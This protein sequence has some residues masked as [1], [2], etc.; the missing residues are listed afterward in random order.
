MGV[1][2]TNTF[3]AEMAPALSIEDMYRRLASYGGIHKF[4]FD[5]LIN[6]G[7]GFT[8]SDW[9]L[10]GFGWG[11]FGELMTARSSGNGG[12]SIAWYNGENK[13]LPTSFVLEL[14]SGNFNNNTVIAFRASGPDNFYAMKYFAGDISF[15]RVRDGVWQ[16]LGDSWY[17]YGLEAYLP[18]FKCR[19][20]VRQV[21]FSEADIDRWLFFSVWFDD[22]LV[23]SGRDHIP[24]YSPGLGF[25]I[26]VCDDGNPAEVQEW[27][28]I[29]VS[30]LSEIIPWASIDPGEAPLDGIQRA[31]ADRVIKSFVRH[32]GAFRVFRP[33]QIPASQ[34]F[35]TSSESSLSFETNLR[36]LYNHVRLYYALDWVEV[37]DEETYEAYGHRFVEMTNTYIEDGNEALREAEAIL[38]RLKQNARQVEFRTRRGGAL[39]EP[40]DRITLPNGEDYIINSIAL[41]YT[42]NGLQAIIRG[43]KYVYDE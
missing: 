2:F 35:T 5:S 7:P 27:S 29:R 22:R 43:R 42:N 40:E 8:S 9:I 28:R 23:L 37:F 32:D 12:Y 15:W 36:E 13:Q 11:E 30:D 6:L 16:L 31:I 3:V 17:L 19:L 41:S 21:M 10:P 20:A 24:E 25:G 18:K 26:G 14:D 34:A 38:L 33:K 1:K 4:E 39:L